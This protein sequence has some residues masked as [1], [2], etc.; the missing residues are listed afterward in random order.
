MHIYF[1]RIS[2]LLSMAV[3]IFG[4]SSPVHA[5]SCVQPPEK[6]LDRGD[7]I[8]KGVVESITPSPDVDEEAVGLRM[9]GTAT[10]SVQKY[11]KGDVGSLVA[12]HNIYAWGT[13]GPFFKVGS[14]Y[15]VFARKVTTATTTT[16]YASIDCGS[17]LL[18]SEEMSQGLDREA[19]SRAPVM[20]SSVVPFARNLTV[21]DTGSDV[22]Q[23]QFFLEQ[24]GFL[25]MPA[26]VSRGYFGS[27]TK[28]ALSR[29]QA[30]ASVVPAYGYFGPITR[31]S[32]L[33]AMKAVEGVI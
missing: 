5:L 19:S 9:G 2:L 31:A 7:V 14:E 26:G 29:Y 24:K 12:V 22:A 13:I 3:M 32:V 17:T 10:F 16:L 33:N 18:A 27:L 8:F 25:V 4:T 6:M 15:I 1:A 20:P 23:L 28:V 21:G 11:W 30:N